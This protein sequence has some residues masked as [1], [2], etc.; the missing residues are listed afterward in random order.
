MRSKGYKL[1][2]IILI[3]K[4]KCEVPVQKKKL[5]KLIRYSG[6]NLKKSELLHII[7]FI[8]GNDPKIA[9]LALSFFYY[10]FD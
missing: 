3:L 7:G 6:I 5:I 4:K 10:S 2:C 1:N 9:I 8:W